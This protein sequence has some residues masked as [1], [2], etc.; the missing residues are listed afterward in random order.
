M[1]KLVV[2]IMGQD[3][4]KFIEMCLKSVKDADK[5][6]YCDGG[7]TDNTKK[8]VFSYSD[9]GEEESKFYNANF[10][11]VRVIENKYNQEDKKMN[12]K[13]RNFYLNYLKENYKGYW[14]L[15]LDA[16]EVVDDL[17]KVTE[18]IQ[19]APKNFLYSPKMRHF[20]Q[21]LGHEDATQPFHN[22]LNRLF[23]VDNNLEYPEVEHPVLQ[24]KDKQSVPFNGATIWHLAYLSGIWD[25]KKKYENHLK[26]SEM[27]TKEYL[28]NWNKAHLFG[29][30]PKTQINLQDIPKIILKEFGVD[31]D[32]FYFMNRGLEPKHSEMVKQWYDYF[33]PSNVLDLGCGRGCYLKYWQW[34]VKESIGVEI[35]NWAR[36]NAFT[37]G[38]V[39]GNICNKTSYVK[40]DLIT[41]I[42]VL[43]HL[44]YEDLDK[45][46]SN[47]FKY[48]S[49]F[50]FSIPFL[51]DPNL[52]ADS[53][54][55]IKE[56]KE[57]WINKLSKYFI[58]KEAPKEW[59]FHEQILIGE[60]K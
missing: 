59:L 48:G 21:D 12:G 56:T 25:I 53:T 11:K 44:N 52:E 54:H 49:R 20:I 4:E 30:Y 57:W 22:V 17:N 13:Q 50:L 29:Q 38:I 15:C 43:E 19:K 18:F 16:D 45:V 37:L 24:G 47:I 1:E 27:H 6:I 41:A 46:L 58:I 8:I 39:K 28:D 33:R 31:K 34:F 3:C 10:D 14:A 5:I 42:D 40:T 36:H 32:E 51:G 55:I 35:S 26:K 9:Y 2:V 23:H 7:S 60:K